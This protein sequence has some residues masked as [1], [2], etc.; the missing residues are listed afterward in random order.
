VT[1]LEVK[2]ERGVED[3][4][5]LP[6]TASVVCFADA[7]CNQREQRETANVS[8][9]D[10]T[11]PSPFT[12]EDFTQAQG[13]FLFARP[14]CSCLHCAMSDT[15]EAPPSPSKS[16]RNN[17]TDTQRAETA[18][19]SQPHTA[20]HNAP[21]LDVKA[22]TD[23]ALQFLA[24]ASNETLGA[25]LVGL[26]A[27]TYLVLGRVGLILIGVVGGV[28]LHATW[29]GHAHG[30]DDV[31][32]KG[33][34]AEARRRELGVDVAHR[35]LDWRDARTQE[36]HPGEDDILDLRVNLYSG[37]SLDF[38][39][40]KPETAAALTELTDAVIRDYVKYVL[41]SLST[42][43]SNGTQMVVLTSLTR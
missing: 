10:A 18:G 25:C 20:I 35:L 9:V 34:G 41:R 1:H 8:V 32:R 27:G 22:L 38:S 40:F 11:C 21:S 16:T 5:E 12:P 31:E 23:R 13:I 36:K 28:V 42:I 15:D 39:D 4:I 19:R 17:P 29:E 30:S 43:L 7:M 6:R 37:K 14:Q 33:R 3:F 2:R 26:S 24:T